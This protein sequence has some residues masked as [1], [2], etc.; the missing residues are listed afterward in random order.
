DALPIYI[1][2]NTTPGVISVS[3]T[4]VASD[5][6]TGADI[7]QTA[8]GIGSLTIVP[9]D[10]PILTVSQVSVSPSSIPGGGTV[11]ASAMIGNSGGGTPASVSSRLT[12]T[13]A[14]N[15]DVTN[16]F[17]VV[18]PTNTISSFAGHSAATTTFRLTPGSNVAPGLYYILV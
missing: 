10:R 16:Q 11:T 12:V 18:P 15:V 5:V 4:V 9:N 8:P 3:A 1:G 2:S 7:S 14:A 17:T 6:A 13:S